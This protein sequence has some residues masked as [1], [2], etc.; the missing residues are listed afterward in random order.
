MSED[1]RASVLRAC[2]E[3]RGLVTIALIE[4]LHGA[5]SASAVFK[6]MTAVGD[7]F[8]VVEGVWGH[9]AVR[10][11]TMPTLEAQALWL[12]TDPAWGLVDRWVQQQRDGRQPPVLGGAPA[13]EHY[14]FGTVPV[15]A[16]LDLPAGIQADSTSDFVTIRTDSPTPLRDVAWELGDYPYRRIEATIAD[17]L[18]D[19]VGIDHVAD[20]LREAAAPQQEIDQD[21]LLAH[22]TQLSVDDEQPAAD[23]QRL[24]ADLLRL[25]GRAELLNAEAGHP[26]PTNRAA[27]DALLTSEADLQRNRPDEAEA[28]RRDREVQLGYLNEGRGT[29]IG[30]AAT[31]LEMARQRTLDDL[32]A[33]SFSEEQASLMLRCDAHQRIRQI[34]PVDGTWWEAEGQRLYPDWQFNPCGTIP[35]LMAVISA[36][37]PG[38]H[39]ASLRGFMTHAQPW[40]RRD[41]HPCSPRLWLIGGGDPQPVLDALSA[42]P[43]R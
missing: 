19:G 21:L 38:Q 12:L 3:Q 40:L 9:A 43:F 28:R 4:R 11:A 8:Q 6:E 31:D 13:L 15:E 17:A 1:V 16:T 32:R 36:A 33:A 10:L 42:T 14:G 39:P 29:S 37:P 18:R 34:D 23:G 24:Y 30:D 35:H 20:F 22:L 7:L 27:F 26:W 2:A 5:A 25:A 41:G